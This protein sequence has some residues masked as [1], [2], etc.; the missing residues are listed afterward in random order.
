MQPTL[1]QQNR[2]KKTL[3]VK[4]FA[5]WHRIQLSRSSTS[6]ILFGILSYIYIYHNN[7]KQT[8]NPM[9][10][11]KYK[12]DAFREASSLS[13]VSHIKNNFSVDK[14]L[15]IYFTPRTTAFFQLLRTLPFTVPQ[16]AI[17]R[18]QSNSNINAPVKYNT[19]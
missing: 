19:L 18:Q 16:K 7:S 13:H 14:V 5:T 11:A 9:R 15:K 12:N 3:K 17:T 1:R 10:Y 4:R 2:K 8:P 6:I